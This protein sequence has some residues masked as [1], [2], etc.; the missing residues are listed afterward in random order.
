[1]ALPHSLISAFRDYAQNQGYSMFI[2]NEQIPT[3]MSAIQPKDGTWK[4]LP[5]NEIIDIAKRNLPLFKILKF[6]EMDMDLDENALLNKVFNRLYKEIPVADTQVLKKLTDLIR[7]A[8]PA[9]HQ[10]TAPGNCFCPYFETTS[11]NK[12]QSS[13]YLTSSI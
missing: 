6:S 4:K 1:M 12:L 11:Y 7:T 13:Y 5:A 2:N 10:E 3:L 8:L 9:Y